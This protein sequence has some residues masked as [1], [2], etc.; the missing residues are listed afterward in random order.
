MRESRACFPVCNFDVASYLPINHSTVL[1][2]MN[3]FMLFFL[4]DIARSSIVQVVIY[5]GRRGGVPVIDPVALRQAIRTEYKL[6]KNSLPRPPGNP[7]QMY[8]MNPMIPL[9]TPV[10]LNPSTTVTPSTTQTP[11]TITS[12]PA[13]T[14]PLYSKY[15]YTLISSNSTEGPVYKWL[16]VTDIP[17][18]YN[19]PSYSPTDTPL[20]SVKKLIQRLLRDKKRTLTQ[21]LSDN[22][23]SLVVK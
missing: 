21:L 5:P 22:Q 20:G 11:M 1:V 17:K 16:R 6:P 7:Y 9:E 23:N 13:T 18:Q 3:S 8:N 12:S 14:T 19:R 4:I 15:K 2:M 10:P